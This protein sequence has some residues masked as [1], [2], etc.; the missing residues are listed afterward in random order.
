M[1]IKTN[2]DSIFNFTFQVKC[3]I[4]LAIG[5]I[6]YIN[7]VSNEFALD[8][9]IVIIHNDYV[10]HGF[11]GI[12]KIL[13]TDA[14][15]SYYRSMNAN[16]MLAGG[17]YRPLS[18]VVFAIEHAIFGGESWHLM[19]L[20]SVLFYILC[21]LTIFYF[22]HNHFFKKMP[23]GEDMA[24]LA[25]VL[26]AIHPMHTEV[27]SNVK[28]LDEILSLTCIVL[29]FIF[30]L[31]Y[32]ESKK[33]W[34]IILGMFFYFLAL[35]AKEYAMMLI[36]IMPILFYL[37]AG[38][39]PFEA[40]F[41][42]LPYYAIAGLYMA[43]R[44]KSVGIPH[45]VPSD[46]ILNNPYMLATHNQ[47]IASEIFVLG[48]YLYMLFFPY[49]LSSDYSYAT[50]PY[51]NFS[52]PMVI[53]T[54]LLYGVITIWLIR[55][56]LKKSILALPIAFYL[57]NLAMVSNFLVD[58][59]AT[60][61]ERLIFHSSLGFVMLLSY[62]AFTLLQKISVQQKKIIVMGGAGLI[63]VLC[64]AEALPRNAQ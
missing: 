7:S 17:R 54:I 51:R 23:F 36:F 1:A 41:S 25:A 8:D 46:E 3:F 61:G 45:N 38:K 24:F 13:S 31:R 34:D 64:L 14:Y 48:R 63:T 52:D 11:G 27:V 15:D 58:I 2:E 47:K 12:G 5:F 28:S 44:I 32:V 20:V 56:L 62:G 53:G 57:V 6:F 59:G 9:G 50:L 43:I 37:L 60:M 16:Q 18:I 55:S 22:L 26:F 33:S 42:S 21:I 40:V 30:S 29:T 4:L 19:H 39:K 10:Q 35:L 49:P